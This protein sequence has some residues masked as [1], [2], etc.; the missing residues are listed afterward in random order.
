MPPKPARGAHRVLL[1]QPRVLQLAVR[2]QLP[3]HQLHLLRAHVP[4]R[5]HGV[6]HVAAL[7]DVVLRGSPAAGQQPLKHA[8]PEGAALHTGSSEAAV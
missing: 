1:R 5:L 4:Q 7:L 3:V 2:L 6:V 8:A